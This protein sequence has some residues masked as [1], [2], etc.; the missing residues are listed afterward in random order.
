MWPEM[1]CSF[2][3]HG[4]KV[5]AVAATRAGLIRIWLPSEL[6]EEKILEALAELSP[7][8]PLSSGLTDRGAALLARYFSGECVTFDLEI[9]ESRFSPFQRLVY[10]AVRKIPYGEVRTYGEI[11]AEIGVSHGARGVGAAMA[12][13]PFPIVIPC[14]RVVGS[15][16]AMTGYS[17]PGG[18]ETKKRFL[19]MEGV[20]L[21]GKGRVRLD[22]QK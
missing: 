3:M 1:F 17:A 7:A 21:D 22:R 9:D 10:G 2:F 13:N 14:H 20:L 16:G 8:R 6:E 15:S 18:E 4:G 5:A 11:A 19:A 12:A